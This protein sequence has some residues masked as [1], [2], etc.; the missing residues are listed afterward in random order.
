MRPS[1]VISALNL[2][3][4]KQRPVFIW[5]PP[6]VGKSDVVAAVAHTNDMQLADIRLNLLDSVDL[7]GFPTKNK[8]GTQMSWLPPD[9]LPTEGKGILFLDEMNSAA[10]SVQAA[11]YQLILNRRIGDYVLPDGW[12]MVAA[13]NREGDRSVV[14]RMPSALANRFVHLDFDVNVDDW[15]AWALDHKVHADLLAFIRFK[16]DLLHKFDPSQKAFPSPRSWMFVNDLLH[17]TLDK[18]TEYEL[19]KGTIGEGATAE[20]VSFLELIR[21]L[22]TIEAILKDPEKI[23]VPES[24]AVRYA[25]TTSLGMQAEKANFERMMKFVL[26]LPVE[27]QVV[28]IRDTVKRSKECMSSKAFT[29]WAI[30]HNDVLT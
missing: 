17:S 3:V 11:A 8:A 29:N 19:F 4:A 7:K 9:F 14:N 21:D 13:G 12:S 2:L 25:L 18:N 10:P 16:S 22:P 5:G 27:F 24:P 23:A 26:R 20:F 30:E 6:G 1:S 28:F 15:A